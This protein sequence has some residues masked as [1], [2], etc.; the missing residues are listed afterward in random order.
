MQIYSNK[1]I[2]VIYLLFVSLILS[3]CLYQFSKSAQ[4]AGLD[5]L[6]LSKKEFPKTVLTQLK[7][8]TSVFFYKKGQE[9]NYDSIKQ[10]ILSTWTLTPVV[11]DIIQNYSKYY[12]NPAYSIF[13]IDSYKKTTET[14][15]GGGYSNTHYYLSLKLFNEKDKGGNVSSW[16]LS[17]IELF[18][19]N[20][21][22]SSIRY[23]KISDA[24]VN[25]I[26]DKDAFFNINPILLKAQLQ[27]LM[28]N[29]NKNLRP[30]LF[31]EVN[32]GMGG[33][34]S[35]DTLYVPRRLLISYNKFNGEES[36][37]TENLFAKFPY[38]YKIC[39]DKELFQI[40]E[41]Q[42]RGRFLFEY[43]KS[44]TDKF[45]TIY[46]L[47]T[48]KIVYKRYTAISYNLKAKDIE[49]IE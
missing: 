29:L 40:F 24:Y 34:L 30:D 27:N 49:K 33:L 20:S 14:R 11:F 25:A 28:T 16:G 22:I 5:G 2:I 12:G 21:T 4:E 32:N 26:Y 19:N 35:K 18:P 41:V 17:R 6:L 23:S 9:A 44:S 1:K 39:S 8:T 47:K 38:K 36:P 13:A 45:V 43:V 3:S 15:S 37:N 48:S 7:G 10:V 42:K 46:D 31:E